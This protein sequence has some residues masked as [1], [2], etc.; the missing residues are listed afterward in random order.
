MIAY[1]RTRGGGA[2][3]EAEPPP[4]PAGAWSPP[5]PALPPHSDDDDATG[6]PV[7]YGSTSEAAV[8]EVAA[9]VIA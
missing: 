4:L 1:L 6:L 2:E 8:V 5:L 3:G 7:A 9:V